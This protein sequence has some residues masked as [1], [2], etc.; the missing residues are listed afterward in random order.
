MEFRVPAFRNSTGEKLM[1]NM[2]IQFL[3]ALCLL[4]SWQTPGHARQDKL[5]LD[6]A[7]GRI[8]LWADGVALK[9]VL[10]QLETLTRI[11]IHYLGDTKETVSFAAMAMKTERLLELLLKDFSH[12]IIYQEIDGSK[13]QQVVE[14]FVSSRIRPVAR[15]NTPLA[16]RA[17][18]SQEKHETPVQ[19]E[20]K[21]PVPLYTDL[22]GQE[23]PVDPMKGIDPLMRFTIATPVGSPENPHQDLLPRPH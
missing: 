1:K 3:L 16:V 10:E 8:T 13:D 4:T 7:E 23:D 2:T 19:P 15:G 20:K 9:T 14:L 5:F 22:P 11:R 12:S 17:F 21:N 6:A 18:S